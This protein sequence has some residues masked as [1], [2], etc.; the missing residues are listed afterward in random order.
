MFFCYWWLNNVVVAN[1][2]VNI[3]RLWHP[4]TDMIYVMVSRELVVY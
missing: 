3:I 1:S 2:M 4:L